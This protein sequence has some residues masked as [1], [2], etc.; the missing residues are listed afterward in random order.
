MDEILYKE[1]NTQVVKELY[2]A[3][4]YLSMASYFDAIGLKG[5][6]HWMKVQAKE[7]VSHAM[8]IY[9]YLNNRTEKVMFEAIEKPPSD[10]KSPMGVFEKTLEHEKKVTKS[11]ENLYRI[12]KEKS[13]YDAEMFLQW[14]IKEQDE[15]EEQAL[16]IL[17]KLKNIKDEEQQIVIL[18]KEL[19]KREK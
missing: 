6:A 18:D 8:K 12:A 13:D 2:S 10:F 4:L 14:F 11:I 7:E 15:E 3:Y 9:D 1:L 16:K 5:F 19:G 17:E